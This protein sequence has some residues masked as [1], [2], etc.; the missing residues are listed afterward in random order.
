MTWPYIVRES[1]FQ[2]GCI[3]EESPDCKGTMNGTQFTK[4]GEGVASPAQALQF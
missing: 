1:H 3:K 4:M 2:E